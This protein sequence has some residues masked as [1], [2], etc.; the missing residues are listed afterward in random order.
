M[1]KIPLGIEPGSSR[2]LKVVV[3]GSKGQLG[4]D[5]LL[6][7]D[8]S[9]HV[10][11][12]GFDLHNVDITNRASLIEAF[13]AVR[14]D[15]VIHTAA[16]TAVD[17][18][19]SEIDLA[20]KINA[21]GTRNIVEASSRYGSH[22]VYISTD[23]VFDGTSNVP[24]L[25][26][27][28]TNPQSVYG[29]SKLAGEMELRPTDTVVRTSWVCGQYGSNMVK[30]VL[31]LKDGVN[32]LKFVN[33]QH[34]CPS[35][36]SDLAV[37]LIEVGLNKLPGRF[38]I[39]NQGPTNWYE[40]VKE[41]LRLAGGDVSRVK[42][43]STEELNPPRPAARPKYSVLDNCALR[44]MGLGPMPDWHDTLGKVIRNLV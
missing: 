35:F 3:T 19:E 9:S 11:T 27:D 33:D 38:H 43:I 14:P 24:Y 36:T 4:T 21:V 10:E 31:S 16:Y 1:P 15:V 25:E 6:A 18:A 41:I 17:K 28:A 30:T 44:L 7:L 26:W 37:K 8:K 22:L 12:V 39:T 29:K 34:G 40:F 2:K 42:A 13:D 20:Y 23:Y 32:E 5:L